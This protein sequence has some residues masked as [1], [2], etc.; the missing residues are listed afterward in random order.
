MVQPFAG[1]P[2]KASC[3]FYSWLA[4]KKGEKGKSFL[5]VCVWGGCLLCNSLLESVLPTFLVT[6]TE[7]PTK[8]ALK[9]KELLRAK[10]ARRDQGHHSQSPGRLVIE[11]LQPGSRVWAGSRHAHCAASR[12]APPPENAITLYLGA[13]CSN[14]GASRGWVTFRRGNRSVLRVRLCEKGIEIASP[15]SEEIKPIPTTA[16][17]CSTLP[18]GCPS[19]GFFS[20]PVLKCRVYLVPGKEGIARRSRALVSL[21][22]TQPDWHDC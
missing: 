6:V 3:C 22:K 19:L 2:V 4:G 17:L 16:V 21:W 11:L 15:I 14:S 13:D 8:T 20:L 12:Q 18:H 7:R 9:K 1:L 10:D 5:Y